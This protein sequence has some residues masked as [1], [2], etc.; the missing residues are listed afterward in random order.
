MP[1]DTWYEEIW[2]GKL[3]EVIDLY[4]PDIIWFDYVLDQIPKAWRQQFSAYYLNAAEEWGKEVV[5]VRKQEDLPGEFSVEDL[6]KSRKNRLDSIPWMTDETISKGSWC[7]TENLE[8]KAAADVLHVLIDIVSKNGVLLLN[9]SPMANGIIPENQQQVLLTMGAWLD[10]YG[11]AIYG[12]RPWYAFGEGPTREP[13]GHFRNHKEFLKIK[14]SWRDVRYTTLGKTIYAT[15]LG[16]PGPQKEVM[17][18]A[19]ASNHLAG[20]QDIKG[21]SMLGCQENIKWGFS[22]GGMTLETP[23]EAPDSMAVVFKIEI[24]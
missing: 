21:V 7:Y 12:T 8:I 13:E 10:K 20:E 24:K 3:K 5:I 4:R 22:P 14:Y 17:L 15:L 11:E 1:A 16:W 9:V 23:S 6:E 19:F 2:Y 18:K